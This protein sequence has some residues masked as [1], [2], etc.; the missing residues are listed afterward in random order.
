MKKTTLILFY[1][2]H[3][4]TILWTIFCLQVS[5]I[6]R[7]LLDRYC[8]CPAAQLG[9]WD[10][11]ISYLI[12]KTKDSPQPHGPLCS[13]PQ[14]FSKKKTR[15]GRSVSDLCTVTKYNQIYKSFYGYGSCYEKIIFVQFW[16]SRSIT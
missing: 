2:G 7:R 11:G 1:K 10:T 4:E 13:W 16:L 12:V 14:K 6:F 8:S 3:C 9:T 15:L 5:E